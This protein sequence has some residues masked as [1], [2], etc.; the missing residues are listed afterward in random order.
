MT[1]EDLRHLRH[2]P[3]PT[4]LAESG[5][6][7]ETMADM[8]RK[9]LSGAIEL[10]GTELSRRL[11]LA[12]SVIEPTLDYLK[13]QHDCEIIGGTLMGGASFRYRL[14]EA[15]NAR[16][17][18]AFARNQYSGLAPVPIGQY[19]AYMDQ[20]GRAVS[21]LVSRDEVRHAFS[22]L[23]IS[24]QMLDELG[25]A[26]SARHSIFIYGPPGNGKSIIAQTIRRLLLG[27]M[28]IPH[29][30]DSGGHIIRFY[31]PALHERDLSE[32]DATGVRDDRRWIRCRRPMI[33]V[34]GELTL[35]DLSLGYNPR[36][37]VYRAPVQT[38]ANGG[39]LVIDD[40]GRQ[41]C[42]PRDLLNW[43]MVP[44]ESRV[45]YMTLQSGDKIEMPF[46]ALV[47]FSTNIRP[48]E[49]VD[50]A[51]LRRIQYKI[52]A[53]NPTRD[54]FIAIFERACIER[55][56]A[57]DRGLVE[58]LI[59]RFYLPRRI[60]LRG[61]HPRDLI[62]QAL[63]LASYRGHARQLTPELLEVACASYF[64]ADDANGE[65]ICA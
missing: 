32:D 44:L 2:P 63:A 24:D 46:Q 41:Q 19:R 15:G 25:P 21:D 35:G 8:V 55:Q 12:F 5:L 7:A 10:S 43:W 59:D 20:F 33:T 3:A 57:F 30:L 52:F 39:I 50:E 16:A 45:E 9:A 60:E 51:F 56:I 54:R 62:N 26:I 47:I 28:A 14:T 49:L 36:S 4:T 29:A 42:P 22:D 1:V 48:T 31:D 53:E 37:G 34:G 27:S 38:L 40:F 13:A 6:G 18:A 11:G 17:Q 64:I 65:R 58:E 23:V 61:C